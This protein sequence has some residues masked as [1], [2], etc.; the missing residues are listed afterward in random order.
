MQNQIGTD[1]RQG[2]DHGN[3][4]FSS[5]NDLDMLKVVHG[6]HRSAHA[7]PVPVIADLTLNHRWDL[8]LAEGAPNIRRVAS[9]SGMTTGL[10]KLLLYRKQD[11]LV[12]PIE[13][14][15]VEARCEIRH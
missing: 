9:R 6:V 12:R 5:A 3:S 2:C 15:V 4:G 14:S 11:P 8:Q 7:Q 10:D 1:V 13:R